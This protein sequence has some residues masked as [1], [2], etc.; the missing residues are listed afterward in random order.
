MDPRS[1]VLLRQAELFQG[2]VLLAGLPA[3]DLLGRLPDAH[4]WCWHAGDQAAL[5][6]IYRATRVKLFGIT[7]RILGDRKEAE[8]ALQDVYVNLWQRADRYDPTR[9]SPIA[10]LAASM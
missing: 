8:D 3:D 7:L 4:G 10:W 1:E 5:E 2:A 9:A 6:E